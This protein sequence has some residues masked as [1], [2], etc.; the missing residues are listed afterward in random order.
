MQ[1]FIYKSLKT[2]YLYLYIDKKYDFTNV[3]DALFD[4]LGKL[5]F[6]MELMLSAHRKLARENVETVMDSLKNKGFFIQL[7]PAKDQP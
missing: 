6:V 1:C 4:K 2:E 7:P 3:P 5:E